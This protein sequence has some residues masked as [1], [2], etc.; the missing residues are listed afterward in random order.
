VISEYH[1]R[2]IGERVIGSGK[3]GGSKAALVCGILGLLAALLLVP[4]AG[5]ATRARSDA[6]QLPRVAVGIIPVD[7]AGQ[8]MYAEAR[9][10]FRKHGLDVEV[11]T[12]LS[13]DQV[14]F[15]LGRG[16]IQLAAM[17]PPTL[18]QA[19]TIG[20]PLRA[21]AGGAIYRPGVPT[22][23]VVAAPGKAITR[24]RDLVGKQVNVDFERS[25]AHLGLLRW[26]ERNG[27]S[28]E[29]ADERVKIIEYPFEQVQGPLLRGQIDAAPL[30]EPWLTW[31]LQRGARPIGLPFDSVCSSD[32]LLTVYV[33]RRD[34]SS[35]VVARFRNAI[36]EAAV[37][38]NKKTNQAASRRILA[39]YA[40]R[41]A[42]QLAKMT[43]TP[44]ATRFRLKMAQPWID[45]YKDYDQIPDSYT[46]QDLVK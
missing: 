7:P 15:A 40:K 13:G 46:V 19:Q 30:P 1:R 31:V 38:A 29:V 10:L 35:N 8:A 25:I 3:V 32:C 5:S 22:T 44:Y 28:R 34:V 14:R 36:Q 23:M 17:P 33:A 9:D 11:K 18:A 26:L 12:Y 45:L 21:I 24:A 39:R 4:T 16:E 41:P 2:H 42:S 27:V 6:A 37:W 20:A 43:R